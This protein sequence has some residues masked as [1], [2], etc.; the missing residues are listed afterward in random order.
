VS[1]TLSP[2]D[3]NRSSFRNVVF[4]RIIDDGQSP[5]PQYNPECLLWLWWSATLFLWSPSLFHSTGPHFN[6]VEKW[7]SYAT[8]SIEQSISWQPDSHE[9]AFLVWKPKIFLSYLQPNGSSPHTIKA[10]LLQSHFNINLPYTWTW[11]GSAHMLQVSNMCLVTEEVDTS[12]N[13]GRYKHRPGRR[14][15]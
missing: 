4:Y 3:G 15:H 8:N 1:P 9:V 12:R 6:A 2:E 7:P 10:Y 14:L 13:V 11:N 5:K